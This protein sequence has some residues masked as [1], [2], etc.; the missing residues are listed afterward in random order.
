MFIIIKTS[1]SV[2]LL[3]QLQLWL[4]N[5]KQQLNFEN[6]MVQMEPPNNSK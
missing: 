3:L 6:A 1:Q 4:D 2:K 5:P